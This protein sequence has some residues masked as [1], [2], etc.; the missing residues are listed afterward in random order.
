MRTKTLALS[1]VLGAL[2]SASVM[3]ANVYSINAVGYVNVTMPPGYSILACPLIA[4]PDNTINTLLNNAP[5]MSGVSPY[6]GADVFVFNN[7]AAFGT[8]AV[9][10]TGS[11]SGGW[12]V[13]AGQNV[14]TLNPGQAVFFFNPNPLVGGA[15][16]TATFVGTVP[17]TG[18]A[19]VPQLP[20]GLTNPI[21]PGY[22]LVSSIVPYSGDLTTGI[23]DFNT[24][25]YPLSGDFVLFFNPAV[26]GG[27][28][29]GYANPIGFSFGSWSTAGQ[30]GA[31]DP[32]TTS[33]T[34]GWMYFNGSAVAG[35]AATENW[36]ETF[37]INP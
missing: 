8:I 5:N 13:P 26:S 14:P 23:A 7:G 30:H 25:S 33:V 28:Q 32:T 29:V 10:N 37:T 3:A 19:A 22:N 1:A 9:G 2:G 27:H 6:S 12:S 17:Q 36:T 11:F 18:E 34:Q 21:V 4:S 31:Y 35:S 20:N 24:A 15:N 16:M